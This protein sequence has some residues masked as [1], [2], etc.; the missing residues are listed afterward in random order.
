MSLSDLFFW[1][2]ADNNTGLPNITGS[3]LAALI[4]AVGAGFPQRARVT[5]STNQTFN[6]GSA[7][8]IDFD[9][10]DFDTDKMWNA[11]NPERLTIN[12][13]GIYLAG[14]YAAW[15]NQ[16]AGG[17]FRSLQLQVAGVSGGVIGRYFDARPV[18]TF[19]LGTLPGTFAALSFSIAQGDWI[20][21]QAQQDSGVA[22]DI[23]SATGGPV[24]WAQR[25]G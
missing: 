19:P 2:K 6:S 7:D 17:N 11:A 20:E 9:T 12:T 18:G 16:N 21:V 4:A 25:V 13:P 8:R 10:V 14:C 15:S 3:E 1:S 24:L 22:L 23:Q 5:R